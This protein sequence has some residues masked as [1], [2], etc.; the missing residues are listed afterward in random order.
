ML[1][2]PAPPFLRRYHARP[3]NDRPPAFAPVPRPIAELPDEL[4][5]LGVAFKYSGLSLN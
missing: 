2:R 5:S 3:M 1:T 4:I